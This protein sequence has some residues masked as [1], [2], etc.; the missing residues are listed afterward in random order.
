MVSICYMC[1]IAELKVSLLSPSIEELG[2]LSAIQ[3]Q[4]GFRIAAVTGHVLTGP[5]KGRENVTV[6]PVG[7]RPMT[8]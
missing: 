7:R 1:E 2:H 3:A 5:S 4:M 6:G 8:A